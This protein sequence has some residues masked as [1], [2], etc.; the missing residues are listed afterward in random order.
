MK[1]FTD[2]VEEALVRASDYGESRFLADGESGPGVWRHYAPCEEGHT[3]QILL[4]ATPEG[5][6]RLIENR[7]VPYGTVVETL[8]CVLKSRENA[9]H[10]AASGNGVLFDAAQEDVQEAVRKAQA[11]LYKL[12]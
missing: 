11:L 3:P 9:M 5:E 10:A 12:T 8:R 4:E 6:L 2:M 1:S 7:A